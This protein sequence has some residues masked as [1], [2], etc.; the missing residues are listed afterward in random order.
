MGFFDDITATF[1]RGADA[2]GRT[3]RTLKLKGQISDAN[4][5]RASFAAQLGAIM[6]DRFKDDPAAREGCEELFAG[7]AACD[8]ERAGYQAEID[9]IEAEAAAASEAAKTLECP[10]CHT[11]VSGGDLFCSGCGMP[12]EE[13]KAAAVARA[14]EEAAG[15]AMCPKCGAP[16]GDDDLFCT[17]CG[18]RI[19]DVPAAEIVNVEAIEKI[20]EPAP[21]ADAKAEEAADGEKPAD[22]VEAPRA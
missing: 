17:A 19:D 20:E 5:R 3:A 15:S 1:N 8:E 21:V 11:R 10:K 9:A 7:I 16:I 22:D 13:I 6:Y 14:E 12:V 18:A 2:A 4:K